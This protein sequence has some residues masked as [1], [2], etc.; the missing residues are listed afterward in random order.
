MTATLIIINIDQN[1][2]K[3]KDI[4]K[5]FQKKDISLFYLNNNIINRSLK[6][7]TVDDL[8]D[9]KD[10]TEID[11]E[12]RK[13]ADIWCNEVKGKLIYYNLELPELVKNEFLKF[14]PVFFK[15]KILYKLLKS[16]N[17]KEIYILTE[18]NEDVLIIEELFKKNRITLHKIL[19]KQS[20]K[21][22][23]KEK[24]KNL[25]YKLIA[26]LQNSLF[27]LYMYKKKNKKN[28]MVISNVRQ[29]LPLLTKLRQ[30][31]NKIIIRAGENLGKALFTD[32]SDYYITFKEYPDK[33]TEEKINR[34]RAELTDKWSLIKKDKKFTKKLDYKINLSRV[35]ESRL[36]K[37]VNDDFIKLIGYIE[38]IKKIGSKIDV[39]IVHNDVLAFEK[40]IVQAANMLNIPTITL[41]EGF[42]SNKKILN[43]TAFVPFSAQIM[44]LHS[45]S[46]K[47]TIIRNYNVPED[48]LRILGHPMFDHYFKLK[49]LN[50]EE[51]YKR[52]KIPINKK[53][54]LYAAEKYNI[55]NK[56]E[57]SIWSAYTEKQYISIYKEL[58]QSVKNIK[59]AFLI[60]KKHPSGIIDNSVIYNIAKE[61]RFNNF[62][63]TKDMD[64]MNIINASSVIILRLSTIGLESMMLGKPI[65]IM[66]TYFDTND[67][68][69][70][71]EF[72]AALHVKKPGELKTVIKNILYDKKL[73][74]NLKKSMQKFIDHHYSTKG[75]A[76]S[77]VAG[78]IDNILYKKK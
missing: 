25:S 10:A 7:K 45:K 31:K 73:N 32:Y 33:D 35:L 52:Y 17:F 63:I 3:A 27:N 11:K 54:I 39:L 62:M 55:K 53:I 64:I 76:S 67:N 74:N 68:V 14:W 23:V 48:R 69:G 5:N 19:L 29:I 40:T 61:E 77:R 57:S 18:Y 60:I 15:I 21:K 34:I 51:I 65:I 38:I 56:Y 2:E 70:Y 4:I 37:I 50:K 36:D 30:D 78:F 8:F 47:E 41:I 43:N 22:Q 49:P 75:G 72:N 16:K 46:Q 26:N 44:I 1:S 9:P 28:I 6:Y 20:Y 59:D 24:I 12:V 58:F 71:T 66:D 42:L 13:L